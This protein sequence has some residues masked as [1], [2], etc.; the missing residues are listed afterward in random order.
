MP[1]V[2]YFILSFQGK[3]G[4]VERLSTGVAVLYSRQTLIANHAVAVTWKYVAGMQG[5]A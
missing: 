3:E 4:K 1:F 2:R 5:D